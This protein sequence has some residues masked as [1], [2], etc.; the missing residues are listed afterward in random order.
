[1]S[2]IPTLDMIAACYCCISAKGAPP[3]SAFSLASISEPGI[4]VAERR[5]VLKGPRPIACVRKA[6]GL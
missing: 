2:H 4:I 6:V 1:M 3:P 5:V